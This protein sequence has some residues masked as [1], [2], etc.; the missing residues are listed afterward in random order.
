LN[1]EEY[2]V[3]LS[4]KCWENKMRNIEEVRQKVKAL[5]GTK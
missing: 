4:E 5:K 1:P 3:D 2:P